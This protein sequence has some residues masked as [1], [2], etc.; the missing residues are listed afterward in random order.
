MKLTKA[1]QSIVNDAIANGFTVE[2]KEWSVE[3]YKGHFDRWQNFVITIGLK[4]YADS[5]AFDMTV[6]HDI[7]KGVRSHADM[8]S[9]LN[10]IQ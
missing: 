9:I 2:H 10:L 3:I 6:D 4:I 5:T 1:K 7:A 8:R